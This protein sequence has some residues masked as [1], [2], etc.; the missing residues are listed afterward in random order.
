LNGDINGLICQLL[1]NGSQFEEFT[2]RKSKGL[3]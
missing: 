2:E 3:K 1:H